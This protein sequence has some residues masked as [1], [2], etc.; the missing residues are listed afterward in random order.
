MCGEYHMTL[1]RS[2]KDALLYTPNAGLTQSEQ[3]GCRARLAASVAEVSSAS[4]LAF[5]QDN[6]TKQFDRLEQFAKLQKPPAVK[7]K[8]LDE[9]VRHRFTST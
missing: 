9:V 7:F 1:D 6:Q 3:M 2:E 5:M 4:E 8:D